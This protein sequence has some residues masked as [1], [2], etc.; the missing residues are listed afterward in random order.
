M[1]P[2]HAHLLA[3][4]RGHGRPTSPERHQNND[5]YGGSGHPFYYVSAPVLRAIAKRW[6]AEHKA[7]T[8]EAF[9]A[10]VENL[11]EGPSHEEKTLAALLVGYHA[12]A[13][14][15]VRPEDVDRWLGRLN[16]WAE[17]DALCQNA[18]TAADLAAD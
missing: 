6:L 12:K 13:R 2:E 1:S 16:G 14:R 11:F 10:V 7:M 5:S 17:I 18:F 3:E 9:L 4:L 15:G 8:S